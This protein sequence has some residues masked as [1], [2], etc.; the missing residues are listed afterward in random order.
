VIASWLRSPVYC[1]T[2]EFCPPCVAGGIEVDPRTE[3]GV[4]SVQKDSV[5]EPGSF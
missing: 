3:K 2:L 1:S 5:E 4:A